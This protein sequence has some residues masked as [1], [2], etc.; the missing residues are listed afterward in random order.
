MTDSDLAA[1]HQAGAHESNRVPGCPTCDPT[2]GPRSRVIHGLV[3]P[4]DAHIAAHLTP[5]GSDESGR[6]LSILQRLVAGYIETTR[7]DRDAIIV[8]NEEGRRLGLP[9]N[10]RATTYIKTESEAQR[11]H[12]SRGTG[13]PVDYALLGDVVI[14]GCDHRTPNVWTNVPERFL[15]LFQVT[16]AG[17]DG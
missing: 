2:P 13:W 5:L 17:P 16:A 15:P 1:A 3:V 9:I 6:Q 12:L 7:Y 11:V 8:V 14:V 4:A 10:W